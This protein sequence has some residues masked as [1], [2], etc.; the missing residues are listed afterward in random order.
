MHRGRNA[1]QNALRY[2]KKRPLA[3]IVV[4]VDCP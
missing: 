2:L 3:I 1:D 4:G